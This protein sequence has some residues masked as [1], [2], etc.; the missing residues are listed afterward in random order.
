M[1]SK[2]K[3]GE[4]SHY[5]NKVVGASSLHKIK[6]GVASKVGATLKE[7]MEIRQATIRLKTKTG[8]TNPILQVGA[9]LP[10]IRTGVKILNK[11][12]VDGATSSQTTKK[13]GAVVPDG[14]Y[15]I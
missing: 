6:V 3:G 7:D 12:T 5:I 2:V 11:I 14:D 10:R 1:D 4:I 8:E 15:R 9:S 13:T